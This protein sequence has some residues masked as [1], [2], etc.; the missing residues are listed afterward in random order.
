MLITYIKGYID[1]YCL[2]FEA[3]TLFRADFYAFHTTIAHIFKHGFD[4]PFL[5]INAH[6]FGSYG[7]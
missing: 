3:Y 4:F 1:N 7:F 6:F 5:Y 2:K